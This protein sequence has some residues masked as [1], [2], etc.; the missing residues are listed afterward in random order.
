MRVRVAQ[1]KADLVQNLLCTTDNPQGVFTTYADIL[2]FAA[3][4]GK[5]INTEFL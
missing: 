2:A 5:K 1:D 3:S 4:L